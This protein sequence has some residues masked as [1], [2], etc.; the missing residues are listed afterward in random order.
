MR[1]S[2]LLAALIA[3]FERYWDD[4][5]PCTSTTPERSAA[6]T[7]HPAPTPLHHGPTA[8]LLLVAGVTDKAIA[9]QL[10]LS[11]RTVQR[12]IQQ[13]MTFAGAATR[14]QLAWQAARRDWV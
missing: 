3:L 1:D 11:R 7:G 13:L 12:H 10:G 9:S 14:M 5:I 2:S 4:A 6:L 8:A